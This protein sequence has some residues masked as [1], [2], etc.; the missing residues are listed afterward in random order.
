MDRNQLKELRP[1]IPSALTENAKEIERFQNEVLR[2]ILKFQHNFFEHYFK[3]NSQFLKLIQEK[4]SRLEFQNKIS[5]FISNQ[6]NIKHQLIGSVIGFLTDEE[7]NY[8]HG[9]S[10]EVNKRISQMASQRVSDTF[11]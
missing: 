2:P 1:L 3:S 8:Y 9:N 11:Y 4:K 10:A 5:Q 7:L 6:S